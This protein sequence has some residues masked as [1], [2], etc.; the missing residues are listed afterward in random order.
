MSIF[1]RVGTKSNLLA[2]LDTKPASVAADDYKQNENQLQRKHTACDLLIEFF[3]LAPFMP[4]TIS[5]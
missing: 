4:D 2:C 5:L 1:L 3:S